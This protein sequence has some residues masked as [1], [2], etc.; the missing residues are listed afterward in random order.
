M[1]VLSSMPMLN[2]IARDKP[3][4]YHAI[5]SVIESLPGRGSKGQ[6]PTS[7]GGGTKYP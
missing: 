6:A 4:E 1:M 2:R 7:G 5:D 3:A